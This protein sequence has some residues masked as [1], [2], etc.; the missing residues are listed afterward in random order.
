MLPPKHQICNDR[1]N[2]ESLRTECR[3]YFDKADPHMYTRVTGLGR[4]RVVALRQRPH[5]AGC[6]V[7]VAGACRCVLLLSRRAVGMNARPSISTCRPV[8]AASSL[9]ARRP[10][11]GRTT[12]L[13]ALAYRCHRSND[14]RDRTR[15]TAALNRIERLCVSFDGVPHNHANLARAIVGFTRCST[16]SPTRCSR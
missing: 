15:A 13:S 4:Q 12:R 2:G 14:A 8:S 6:S 5:L 16:A 11:L 3:R 1:R 10:V 7:E 9:V